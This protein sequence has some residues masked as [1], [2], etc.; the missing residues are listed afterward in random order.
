MKKLFLFMFFVI[1][2]ATTLWAQTWI[3]LIGA[4]PKE[5]EFLLTQSAKK[6]IVN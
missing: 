1:I 6:M 5:P 3:G 2:C 4:T